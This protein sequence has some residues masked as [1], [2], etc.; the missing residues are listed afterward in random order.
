[1]MRA[2]AAQRS[3]NSRLQAVTVASPAASATSNSNQNNQTEIASSGPA[4]SRGILNNS[5]QTSIGHPPPTSVNPTP[6]TSTGST[7]SS[8]AS[9]SGYSSITGAETP[10]PNIS[11]SGGP[12]LGSSRVNPA[13]SDYACS[14]ASPNSSTASHTVPVPSVS[15]SSTESSKSGTC[16]IIP[17]IKVCL[18]S[19]TMS[20]NPFHGSI[21]ISVNLPFFRAILDSISHKYFMKIM[22]HENNNAS[23]KNNQTRYGSLVLDLK[24]DHLYHSSH[25]T[26][27]L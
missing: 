12:G 7:T 26:G 20:S 21:L 9:S 3:P 13:G 19:L 5:H 16:R 25:C 24:S 4:R 27:E 23:L 15:S 17:I 8:T 18:E 11:V 22:V 2:A 1:M 10:G 14:S 6:L